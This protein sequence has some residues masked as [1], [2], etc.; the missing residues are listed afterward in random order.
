MPCEQ[1]P[2]HT[3]DSDAKNQLRNE[4]PICRRSSYAGTG[5]PLVAPINTQGVD[6]AD[7]PSQNRQRGA[8]EFRGLMSELI[9]WPTLNR[10][11]SPCRLHSGAESWGG[12]VAALRQN[13]FPPLL[14][15]KR[16]FA[17]R[18]S[19]SGGHSQTR[20]LRRR[21]LGTGRLPT[22]AGNR[23]TLLRHQPNL[24]IAPVVI[25][26]ESRVG[27]AGVT[28]GSHCNERTGVRHPA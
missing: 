7:D 16:P 23:H 22:A 15:G 8:W 4:S 14:A 3:A 5:I 1:R 21:P 10:H 18:T 20:T 2:L 13:V 27:F 17:R 25:G 11:L 6:Q 26:C 24:H 9:V 12:T 19:Q 28:S